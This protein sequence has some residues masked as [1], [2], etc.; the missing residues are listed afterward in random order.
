MKKIPFHELFNPTLQALHDLG[1]SGTNQEIHDK[2]VGILELTEDEIAVLHKP[3]KSNPTRI[4]NKLSW[5]RTWLKRYGLLENSSRGVWSL[6]PE[7]KATKEVDGNK[8][9]SAVREM[10]KQ[11]KTRTE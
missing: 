6:T 3:G 1:E 8:V 10:I 2:A 11:E 7:R 5:T 9:Y 4:A